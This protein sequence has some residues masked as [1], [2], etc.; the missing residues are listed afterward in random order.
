MTRQVDLFDE[1]GAEPE[2]RP[3]SKQTPFTVTQL[4]EIADG[5]L[6]DGIGAIWVQ[7]ELSRFLAH[8]SGHWYFTLVDGSAAVSCAMF[9]GR[10]SAA[11]FA[12][13]D[14][15]A[16][17]ALAVPGIYTSQGRY[18]LICERLEPLG[19]GA[20]AL[21]FEQLR[22][23]LA[24]EGLFDDA[25]KR[26]LPQF[27]RRVGIVTSIEGAALRDVLRVLRRRFAGLDVL[28]AH[29]AVQ[30]KD[31]ATELVQALGA[32]DRRG[33]D[34]LLIVRGG[35]A[36]E[37]LAAFD[38]ERVVRAVAGCR[39]PIV[40]G[41][42]HETDVTLTDFAADLRASTP[43]AAAE[44]IV[45]EHQ[46]LSRRIGQLAQSLAHITRHR[47]ERFARRLE[48]ARSARGLAAMERRVAR[49]QL[50]VAELARRLAD[51]QLQRVA[52]LRR[53]VES[54]QTRLS[55]TAQLA[56]LHRRRRQLS[57][58]QE[59]LRL[60]ADRITQPRRER[61]GHAAARLQTLSPLAVLARGYSLTTLG[62]ASGAI[63]DDAALL[64]PGAAL[65]VRFA[66][67]AAVAEVRTIELDEP[68]GAN[69]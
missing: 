68:S 60:A 64:T 61:V 14:G 1:R 13:Q 58:A 8:Q 10:N 52:A 29:A 39:T 5:A 16:V 27:P 42:G 31:A 44:L 2:P 67:G 66:R 48:T 53:L 65:F 9:R 12:P 25:R 22:A 40:S 37:D 36:R 7:G 11:R 56:R 47:L 62:V 51:H 59:R 32:L 49:A 45:R 6:R 20:A 63:V 35:G 18:Q 3:G 38:D 54:L 21:A 23:K 50:V 46:E 33:L 15:V 55:P 30:G 41:V 17:L 19:H 28:V 26:P 43:S 34:V 57:G 24:A 4:N 69:R